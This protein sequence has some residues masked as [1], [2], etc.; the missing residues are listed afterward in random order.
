MTCTLKTSKIWNHCL[1]G[2]NVRL[3]QM[4][5]TL[6]HLSHV[7]SKVAPG[8]PLIFCGDFNSTPNS[9]NSPAE[10][11]AKLASGLL[12]YEAV[13]VRAERQSCLLISSLLRCVPVA[14]WGCGSSAACRLEQL[15]AGGVLRYGA[16]LYL[17]P[18]AECLQS[19][20]VHQLRRRIPRLSGLHLHTAREH[21]GTSRSIQSMWFVMT[22]F[23]L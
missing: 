12:C 19:A 15:R 18:L 7:M 21:A 17:P 23:S 13:F 1:E 20:G 10:G 2:G 3:V 11:M 4:G 5:V 8:A 6:K 9:G 14:Q 16:T 22:V